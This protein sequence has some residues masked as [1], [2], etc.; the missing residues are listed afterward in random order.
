MQSLN[1]VLHRYIPWKLHNSHLFR[2]HGEREVSSHHHV[3]GAAQPSVQSTLNIC[4]IRLEKMLATAVASSMVNQSYKMFIC[5]LNSGCKVLSCLVRAGLEG[6]VQEVQH[7]L[8]E[9]RLEGGAEKEGCSAGGG[10]G[11]G[12]GLRGE[13]GSVES[14]RRLAAHQ[15]ST[16]LSGGARLP[17]LAGCRHP[18]VWYRTGIG[19]VSDGWRVPGTAQQT[20]A[21]LNSHNIP[22]I[23]SAAD[24]PGKLKTPPS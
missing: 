17:S 13:Q 2:L 16:L 15:P 21:T 12:A 5:C 3:P 19:R 14:G 11:T 9:V 23:H 20:R 18:P 22:F 10:R 4:I 8:G 1:S 7:L 6:V 24:K